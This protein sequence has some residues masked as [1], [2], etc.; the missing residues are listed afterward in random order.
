LRNVIFYGMRANEFTEIVRRYG[1]AMVLYARQWCDCPEDV[2]QT[3]FLKLIKQKDI[4][5]QTAG[6][7]F[8]VVRNAAIDAGRSAQRR[9]KYELNAGASKPQSFFPAEFSSDLDHEQVEL[10]LDQLPIEIREVIIAHIW[11]GL[12]FEQIADNLGCS[13]STA[14]RRYSE[15]LDLLR[16]QLNKPAG[17]KQA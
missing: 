17:Q 13:A 1:P 2:V 11:G 3:A 9:R 4:P 8:Q 14:F 10:L 16:K 6:W 5:T 7:L 15:G 12:T